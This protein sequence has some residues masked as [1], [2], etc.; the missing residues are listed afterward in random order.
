MPDKGSDQMKRTAR[1]KRRKPARARKK[2][3]LIG[4]QRDMR[5][6]GPRSAKGPVR[7]KG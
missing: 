7:N 4:G 2:E 5:Y 3:R 1:M 6:I